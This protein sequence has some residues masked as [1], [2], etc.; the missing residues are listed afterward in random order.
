MVWF[1][2]LFCKRSNGNFYFFFFQAEDGIRD[3]IVT[4][5]QTCALPISR[6]AKFVF[7]A[8]ATE[9]RLEIA[10]WA[11]AR[12]LRIQRSTQREQAPQRPAHGLLEG[13]EGGRWA[14][15]PS[16]PPSGARSR[17]ASTRLSAPKKSRC[18]WPRFR[19]VASSQRHPAALRPPCPAASP[20]A[21]RPAS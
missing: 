8:N 3:L 11:S 19:R 21:A 7:A 4:G 16:R 9:L 5:V 12:S 2:S 14:R 18:S 17:A 6:D 15:I 10:Y 13:E 1:I 20:L